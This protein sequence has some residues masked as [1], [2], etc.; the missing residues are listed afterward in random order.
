MLGPVGQGGDTPLPFLC[1]PLPGFLDK[2]NDLLF[3]NLKEVR[4][5][6]RQAEVV[7]VPKALCASLALCSTPTSS[8]PQI[9]CSS[10]NPIMCQCFDRNELSDKKR[11]ETVRRL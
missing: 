4:Q 10:K 11:P 3:R 6:G 5:A 9:M 2:N 8:T 7:W 1:S